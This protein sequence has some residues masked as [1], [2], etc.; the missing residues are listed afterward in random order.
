[1]EQKEEMMQNYW[2]I[3][4]KSGKSE[5]EQWEYYQL[6]PIIYSITMYQLA[7]EAIRDW[8]NIW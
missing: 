6:N 2:K 1:M 8:W 5:V 3:Y 7:I 4:E